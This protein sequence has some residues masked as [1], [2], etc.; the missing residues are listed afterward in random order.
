M[1]VWDSGAQI[2]ELL[3]TGPSLK[4]EEEIPFLYKLVLTDRRFSQ[5]N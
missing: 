5:G 1:L 4:S 2:Q 3:P